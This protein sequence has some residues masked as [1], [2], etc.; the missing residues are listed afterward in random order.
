[1]RPLSRT[2]ALV[3]L[4]T[5]KDAFRDRVVRE[6]EHNAKSCITC[7]TKGACCL[8][9]HFVNVR[10]SRLEAHAMNAAIDM[11]PAV[12]RMAVLSRAEMAVETHGLLAAGDTTSKGYACPLFERDH[13]CLVHDTGKPLACTAHACYEKKEDLPPDQMLAVQEGLVEDLNVQTYGR[14]QP[15]LPIPLAIRRQ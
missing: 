1:M 12:R 3:K 4:K 10:I 15:W 7:E 5:L 14:S 9:A 6:Y 2:K 11:M 8:D 13:G